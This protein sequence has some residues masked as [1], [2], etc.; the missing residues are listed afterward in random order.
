MTPSFPTR[1]SSDLKGIEHPDPADHDVSAVPGV[2]HEGKVALQAR[3]LGTVGRL[4]HSAGIGATGPT[5]WSL[6]RRIETLIARASA[7]ADRAVRRLPDIMSYLMQPA[8]KSTRLK[9][10]HQCAT[11]MP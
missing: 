11:R 4:A 2:S 9:S 5:S 7:I 10:S 3:G 8:R 1:R 6:Q